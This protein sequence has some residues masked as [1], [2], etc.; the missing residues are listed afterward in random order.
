[1]EFD[2]WVLVICS[3]VGLAA[4]L[5]GG[6]LGIGGSIIMIPALTEVFGPRQHLYQAA[7]MIVNFFVV[8]PAFY[9]HVRAKA[10]MGAVVRR[11]APVAVAAVAIGVVLSELP[12]FR[13]GGQAYLMMVF[14]LFL[15]YAGVQNLMRLIDRLREGKHAVTRTMAS[16]WK[17]AL[18]AGVPMGIVGGLLG[19][20]GGIVAVPVQNRM[21]GIPLRN[22]IANSATTIIALSFIGAIAKNYALATQHPTYTLGMSFSI[23]AILI[24]SAIVGSLIGGRLTHVLPVNVVRIVLVILLFIA[25]GRMVQRGAAAMNASRHAGDS[26]PTAWKNADSAPPTI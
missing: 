7:C 4:G 14:G 11:M 9:Q 18:G 16:P 2:A 1:M 15:A 8:V 6:M 3:V 19:V 26:S 17:V 21:L 12:V 5:L 13:S 25:A 24:P 20:G 10:V 22:A 23:A